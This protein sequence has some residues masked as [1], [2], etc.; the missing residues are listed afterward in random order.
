MVR[1][2]ELRKKRTHNI[3]Y[4]SGIFKEVILMRWEYE[5]KGSRKGYKAFEVRD[6]NAKDLGLHHFNKLTYLLTS[7]KAVL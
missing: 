6:C 7:I 2:F 1:H 5:M 3:L 4:V